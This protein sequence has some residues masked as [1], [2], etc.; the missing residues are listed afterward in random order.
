MIER[1]CGELEHYLGNTTVEM[2][3]LKFPLQGMLHAS[4]ELVVKEFE[5][6]I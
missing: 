5:D 4:H 3:W 1:E 2:M 6:R